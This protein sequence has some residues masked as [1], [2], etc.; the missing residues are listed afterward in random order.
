MGLMDGIAQA[1]GYTRPESDVSQPYQGASNADMVLDTAASVILDASGNGTAAIGPTVQ[2][3][4]SGLSVYV[5]AATN[6]VE[7]QA[8]L[9]IGSGISPGT[10]V[11]QTATGSSGDTWSGQ[12]NIQVYLGQRLTVRWQ[13]GD[14]GALATMSV[15]GSKTPL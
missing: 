14:P 8:T 11:A 12:S 4:W 10:A 7:A 2:E 9:Y 1:L 6:V 13:G 5:S 3:M 15:N